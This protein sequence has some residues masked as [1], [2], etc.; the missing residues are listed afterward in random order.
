MRILL[1]LLA[2]LSVGFMLM[3][4][5]ITMTQSTASGHATEKISESD[6]EK[7]NT[8]I[9]TNLKGSGSLLGL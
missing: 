6:S 7:V 1:L 2:L 3:S 8:S 4:C 5:T 9:K